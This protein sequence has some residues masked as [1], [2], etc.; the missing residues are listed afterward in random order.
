MSVDG[1]DALVVLFAKL[2]PHLDK[3]SA[4]LAHFPI[5]KK[6]NI[7]MEP[8][9]RLAI[10]L[11]L[12]AMRRKMGLPGEGIGNDGENGITEGSDN[13]GSAFSGDANTDCRG[14]GG[15]RDS[16]EPDDGDSQGHER[17]YKRADQP[18]RPDGI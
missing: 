2:S 5:F 6:G 3:A 4:M 13:E 12:R 8:E 17:E 7:E 9:E 18:D 11:R 15:R 16:G 1:G 14:D 10:Y